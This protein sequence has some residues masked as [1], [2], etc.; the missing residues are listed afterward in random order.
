MDKKDSTDEKTESGHKK[1]K[2]IN[3]PTYKLMK[4]DSADEQ[5]E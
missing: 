4:K 3:I 1:E 5:T 2:N